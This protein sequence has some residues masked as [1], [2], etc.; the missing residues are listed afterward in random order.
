M[1]AERWLPV[2]GFDKQYEVSDRGRVRSLARLVIDKYGRRHPVEPRLLAQHPDGQGRLKVR[3]CDGPRSPT[4]KVHLLVLEAFVGPRP[5]GMVACHADDDYLNN[6]LLNLRWDTLS[7]NAYDSVRN[8]THHCA[9]K[10]HCVRNHEFTSENTLLS[11]RRRHCRECIRM[12][13][14]QQRKQRKA[15]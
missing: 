15:A 2:P 9:S 13:Q 3:L 4:R 6:H 1:S 12:R 5:D 10:T 8:G 11:G 7:A 14:A